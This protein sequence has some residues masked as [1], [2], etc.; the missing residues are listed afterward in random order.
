[1]APTALRIPIS[2][3]RSVTDTSMMFITPIPPTSS[4]IAATSPSRVVNTLLLAAEVCRIEPWL[5]TL[6][7]L[8]DVEPGAGGLSWLRMPGDLGLRSIQLLLGLRLHDDL[9]DAP[10]AG[11]RVL[12]R[13][14]RSECDV[15]LIGG[16]VRALRRGDADD[17]VVGAVDL[18]RGADRILAAE[19]LADDRRPDD[20]QRGCGCSPALLVNQEPAVVL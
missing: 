8:A 5:M 14:Q 13:G 11:E 1:M 12:N 7:L 3:V 9:A 20:Q 10:V 16:P 4:E 17:L 19:Q 2:R 6:K 18:D 15:V